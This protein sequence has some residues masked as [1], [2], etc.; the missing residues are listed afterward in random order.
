VKESIGRKL[1][2]GAI[3]VGRALLLLLLFMPIAPVNAQDLS[4]TSQDLAETVVVWSNEFQPERTARQQAIIKA[5]EAIHPNVEVELAVM[6]E[7]LMDRMMAQNVAVNTPPDIVIHPLSLTARWARQG[8]LDTDAAT[9]I[10]KQLGAETFS[11]GALQLTETDDGSYA[12]IP[13]DGW[14]QLLIYRKDWFEAA[15]LEP[16][17]SYEAIAAAAE[18]L[19]DPEKGIVGFLGASSPSDVYTWQVFEHIALA[20]GASFVDGAGTITF[21]STKMVEAIQ[22]Y[23]DLMKRYGPRE[24]DYYWLQTRADYLAGKGAMVVWSPFILDE[25]AGLR[26]DAMPTCRECRQNRRF[27]AQN[28]GFV[29]A[30]RGFSNDEPAAWGSLNSIGITPNASPM[31][32]EFVEYWMG[33]AYVEEL[34]LAP[35]GKFPMRRGTPEEPELFLQ[36]WS[37]LPVGV[38]R[39]AKLGDIYD[40][41]TLQTIVNGSEGYSRMGYDEGQSVLAS[42]ISSQTFIQQNLV[43]VLKGKLSPRQAAAKIQAEIENLQ[44]ELGKTVNQL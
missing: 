16:P 24:P 10:V 17:N 35:E 27:I 21:D 43:E 2:L 31:A 3:V 42:D 37:E 5:F 25:L 13:T 36:E 1:A 32:R 20:N 9:E 18:A 44:Q 39:F 23:A 28:S 34:A 19:N 14:G 29:S 22:F 30:I 38:N 15:G 4:V 40:E 12:A 26:N 8:L 6:D 11:P 33:G 41:D 7:N